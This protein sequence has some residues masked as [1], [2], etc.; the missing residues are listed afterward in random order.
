MQARVVMRMAQ[1]AKPIDQ[2]N[3]PPAMST[4]YRLQ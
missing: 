4:L 3:D 2:F 1:L